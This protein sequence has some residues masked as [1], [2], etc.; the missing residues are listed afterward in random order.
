[1][2][3]RG[4]DYLAPAPVP[5]EAGAGWGRCA[6]LGR[7]FTRRECPVPTVF[8]WAVMG[9]GAWIVL[10]AFVL[11]VH[12]FLA[13]THPVRGELLIVEGWL[14]KYALEEAVE[15]FRAG[16]YRQMVTV[17]GPI[18]KES[19]LADLLPEFDSLAQVSAAMLVKMGVA[20]GR[21]AAVPVR[22]VPRNRTY[23][24]GMALREWLLARAPS[25]ESVDV[26]SLGPHARRS[27]LLF[28]R[29]FEGRVRVGV[30]AC[31]D[32]SYDPRRW[33]MS[34]AGGRKVF[35]E[36]LAYLYATVPFF[37]GD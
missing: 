23:T 11:G 34:S 15:L 14:P 4:G 27:R 36:V 5:A 18:P 3:R 28:E 7:F 25:A 10:A 35:G 16:G 20:E 22:P 26:F 30:V 31:V 37:I 24:S 21:I 17:G 2:I 1:M 8:G 29:A 12:P 6:D 13:I 33:W 32:R 19:Y 9:V